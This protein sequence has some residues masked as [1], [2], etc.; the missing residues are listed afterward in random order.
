[1]LVLVVALF[2]G[3]AV[4]GV[5]LTVIAERMNDR[6]RLLRDDGVDTSAE[7]T[8]LTRT[9][10]DSQKHF[11]RYRFTVEG[12][13][14]E[15]FEKVPRRI[16]DNLQTGSTL[17]VRYLPANPYLNHPGDWREK[18]MPAGLPFGVAAG[19]AAIG[20][21]A[22]LPILRQRRLVVEGRAA[23]G[24]V[25]HHKKSQ[26][27]QTYHYDFLLLSGATASGHSGE[28]RHPPAIGSTISVL[29]DP[30]NPRKNAPYP[31][32]LIRLVQHRSS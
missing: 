25:T 29:Y 8:S 4:S 18:T 16:W 31:V 10:G 19:L 30:E 15:G 11:V 9:R 13:V 17:H 6:Q 22:L 26:H 5:S 23:P 32:S 27:G 20:G 2:A 21:L 7:V 28:T 24:L 14:Y 1:M 3:A 12:R